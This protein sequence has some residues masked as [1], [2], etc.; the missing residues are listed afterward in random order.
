MKEIRELLERFKN[1]LHSEESKK[2]VI[3]KCISEFTPITVDSNDVDFKNG[4]I[5]LNIKPIYKNEIFLKKEAILI[6][7]N[8]MLNKDVFTDI[9]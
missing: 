9:K 6:S 7:I 5:Y 2:E 3:I 1:I 4:I 8:T